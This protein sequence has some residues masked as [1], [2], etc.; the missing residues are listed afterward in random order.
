MENEEWRRTDFAGDTESEI[1]SLVV[2][3]HVMFLHIAEV[4]STERENQRRE[5]DPRNGETN[6]RQLRVVQ[7]V[8]HSV[9][10]VSNR[11]SRR[12]GRR[13]KVDEHPT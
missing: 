6:L 5:E 7:S 13:R 3:L 9:V 11:Q 10:C 12:Q 1:G 2:V 4:L 8:V